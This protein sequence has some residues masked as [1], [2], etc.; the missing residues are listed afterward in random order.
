RGRLRNRRAI[1]HWQLA[2]PTAR[3]AAATGCHSGGGSAVYYLVGLRS[4]PRGGRRAQHAGPLP[5]RGNVSRYERGAATKRRGEPP[6][7]TIGQHYV[8]RLGRSIVCPN[9]MLPTLSRGRVG[10]SGRFMINLALR[11]IDHV[12]GACFMYA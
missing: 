5:A 11:R 2:A 10:W 12:P 3:W 8:Y 7:V 6:T 1:S 4:S 9:R